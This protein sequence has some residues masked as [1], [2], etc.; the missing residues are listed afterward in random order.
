MR[1]GRA[2][3]GALATSPWQRRPGNG[4]MATREGGCCAPGTEGAQQQGW[5]QGAAGP[6]TRQLQGSPGGLGSA[7]LQ[8]QP[9]CLEGQKG[10]PWGTRSGAGTPLGNHKGRKKNNKATPSSAAPHFT[11][12]R[13]LL[14]TGS[15]FAHCPPHARPSPARPGAAPPAGSDAPRGR[16]TTNEAAG[17]GG[18]D[19]TGGTP[20]ATAAVLGQS[21]APT[22]AHARAPSTHR[23]PCPAL[24]LFPA[25]LMP[26]FP[27]SQGKP[28]TF[29]LL[30]A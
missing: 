14:Q 16:G 27:P 6:R 26:L 10:A 20:P 28:V 12:S 2:K 15:C 3:P 4:A 25:L 21:H 17:T 1:D 22:C 18:T 11:R 9:G 24:Q 29:C 13:A 30:P 8:P 5:G 19:G 7:K 23:A